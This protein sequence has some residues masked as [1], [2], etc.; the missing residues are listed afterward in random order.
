VKE[1]IQYLFYVMSEVGL[2]KR[3]RLLWDGDSGY[4]ASLLYAKFQNDGFYLKMKK[5]LFNK[6]NQFK[7]IRKTS[8]KIFLLKLFIFLECLK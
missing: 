7:G 4:F 2:I 1:N 6:K 3:L 8:V 5:L